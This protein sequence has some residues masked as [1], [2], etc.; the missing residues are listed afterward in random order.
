M[1]Q[2]RGCSSTLLFLSFLIRSQR[3]VLFL[4]NGHAL[5]QNTPLCATI[6]HTAKTS[7][8]GAVADEKY[9]NHRNFPFCNALKCRVLRCFGRALL[10]YIFHTAFFSTVLDYIFLLNFW[11]IRLFIKIH[12][13]FIQYSREYMEVLEM[14]VQNFYLFDSF[15]LV[16]TKI[17]LQFSLYNLNQLIFDA[18]LVSQLLFA[19]SVKGNNKNGFRC[20]NNRSRT[21]EFVFDPLANYTCRNN[22]C[23]LW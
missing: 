8:R 3:V 19:N 9:F 16:Q 14:Q 17:Q 1:D 20:F 13:L 4:K 11:K 21:I 7:R 2:A 10:H 15:R 6:S 18:N 5:P 22:D 12:F 23:W